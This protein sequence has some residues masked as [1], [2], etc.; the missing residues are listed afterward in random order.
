VYAG[1]EG[2]NEVEK[3]GDDQADRVARGD[4]L[5]PVGTIAVRERG[6]NVM[7][8]RVRCLGRIVV[9][10]PLLVAHGERAEFIG[11]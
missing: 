7:R 8:E 6:Y 4:V 9:R 5:E 11:R 1:R 2:I 3:Q 10:I